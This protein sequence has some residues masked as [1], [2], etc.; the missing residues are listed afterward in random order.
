M[1]GTAVSGDAAGA[2]QWFADGHFLREASY[3]RSGHDLVL[4]TPGETGATEARIADFFRSQTPP[5]LVAA[6]GTAI[7]PDLAHALAMANEP[8]VLAQAGGG[9]AGQAIGI[10]KSAAGSVSATRGGQTVTL[11]NN[12]QVFQ[13]D[14]VQTGSGGK[15]TLQFADGTTFSLNANARMVLDRLV[16][17]P[18]SKQGSALVSVVQGAFVFVS[19]EI[20]RTDPSQMLVRTPVATIGI[21]GTGV[22]GQIRGEGLVNAFTVL[23]GIIVLI[24]GVDSVTLD[25]RGESTTVTGNNQPFA[26]LA[27]L[28]NQDIGQRFG[29][30]IELLNQFLQPGQQIDLSRVE[31]GEQGGDTASLPPTEELPP[32]AEQADAT[33]P[34]AGVEGALVSLQAEIASDLAGEDALAEDN[35]FLQLLSDLDSDSSDDIFSA[36]LPSGL[37]IVGS[38]GAD[39][40]VG[41]DG[42]DTIFGAAGNDLIFGSPGNDFLAGGAGDDLIFG[43]DGF[44]LVAF[45]GETSSLF[46]DVSQGI[47]SGGSLG[48]DT[49]LGVEGFVALDPGISVVVEG[50]NAPGNE[51][52]L[53]GGASIFIDYSQAA[54]DITIDTFNE[55]ASGADIGTDQFLIVGFVSG[56]ALGGGNDAIFNL[57]APLGTFFAGGGG[58]DQLVYNRSQAPITVDFVMGIVSAPTGSDAISGIEGVSGTFLDD[59][60]LSSPAPEFMFGA[61]GNDLFAIGIGPGQD[62]LAGFDGSDTIDFSIFGAAGIIDLAAGQANYGAG[63]AILTGIENAIG[64]PNPD[65]IIGDELANILIGNGGLDTLL[66]NGGDDSLFGGDGNDIIFAGAGNDYITGGTGTGDIDGESG[67]DIVDFSVVPGIGS[68]IYSEINQRGQS[69]VTNHLIF[70]VEVVIGTSSNDTFGGAEGFGSVTFF[71][72][73]GT[74]LIDYS[75]NTSGAIVDLEAGTASAISG[76]T[77]QLF[78]FENTNGGFT[79]DTLRGSSVANAIDGNDGNDFI[80]GRGGPDTLTGGVA[81]DDFFYGQPGDGNDVITDFLTANDQI[82]LLQAAFGG[83][84][85]GP[86]GPLAAGINFDQVAGYNGANGTASNSVALQPV[87]V[88]DPGIQTLYYDANGNA[89]GG[90]SVIAAGFTTT[91]VAT[92]IIL[93]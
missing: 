62:T 28:S 71:G 16:Y 41:G 13:G 23:A 2:S 93:V 18:A 55:T 3:H 91:P 90:Q 38:D 15:V 58:F 81:L 49:V 40:L 72:L 61:S 74:D 79:N 31:R 44:D 88:Y 11:A 57:D 70:N 56:V 7:A 35:L 73:A 24:N 43:G 19:G 64:G 26:P 54:S 21:R 52:F 87:V 42:D 66:G 8:I 60:F 67:I 86:A 92:D 63:L 48:T 1:S 46:I 59:T 39:I 4:R 25:Q 6:D 34:A 45:E 22:G 47:V 12:T 84:A 37:F 83:A 75:D 14:V 77:W 69:N 10:V 65:T 51:F 80:E 53:L 68:L 17:D 33:P 27:I 50:A 29:P 30:I 36:E 20:A 32:P 89:G 5:A 9:A 85:I 82:L 76:K 78:S